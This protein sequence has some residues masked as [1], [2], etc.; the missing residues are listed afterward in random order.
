MMNKLFS[1]IKL[2]KELFGI[3]NA[4]RNVYDVKVFFRFTKL[5]KF[6]KP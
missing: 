3:Y 4:C 1:T 5:S 2:F 6:S